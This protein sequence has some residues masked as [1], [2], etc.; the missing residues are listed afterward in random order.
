MIKSH[1]ILATA[2]TA[3]CILHSVLAA[4]N[5]KR[6]MRKKM[7][8]H[9]SLYRLFY[10]SFALL[11][12]AAIIIYE[13]RMA[14]F[15]LFIPLPPVLLAGL[16]CCFAGAMV[17]VRCMYKYFLR[18]SGLHTA[19]GNHDEKVLFTDGL[20]QYVRHPL[21][22]GT[23]LFIWGAFLAMPYGSLFVSNVILTAY[24][25][26]GIRL[27]EKKLAQEFGEAYTSYR[28]KVPMI[29]PTFG[30]QLPVRV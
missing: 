29:I 20:N 23:L 25:L 12:F 4:G 28:K 6:Y 21:Y 11:S 17:M 8:K 30:R 19:L 16:A 9:F 2:W 18:L 15:Y 27:E 26:V 24:T 7:G 13:I 5:V 14:T 10:T 22:A 1:L 3:F